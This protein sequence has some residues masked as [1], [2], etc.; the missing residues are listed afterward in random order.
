[1]KK[2]LL[3]SA[4]A[5][6]GLVSTSQAAVT[7]KATEGWLESGFV[8]WTPLE[9]ATGYHVYCRPSGG[10]YTQLD[11]ELVRNYNT[12]GR[13]DVL[14]IKAGEYQFKVVP[15]GADGAEM[16]A[17]ATE[18]PLFTAAAHDR[19]G[20]AHKGSS[21]GIGAY[22]NDGTLKEG[23]R[24]LYVNAN[25]A[26]TV[27]LNMC[28]DAKK[29]T[30]S[31]HVGLQTILAAYEK[32]AEMRPLAIRIV[33]TIKDTN[34]DYIG[35]KEEGLQIKGHAG[36][37]KLNLTIEGVGDDATLH[38]Y[39]MI[40]RNTASVELR[41]FG[42][43]LCLDDAI[44]LDTDNSEIWIHNLD[45]FYGKN[46]GGD[47][48]KGDGSIDIK[49]DSKNVT[50]AYNHL[51]DTG[52]SSLGGMKSESTSSFITYH[53]NWFDH[54][55]SRHPRIRTMSV[56]VFNNYFDGN[57]KYGVGMTYGGSAFVENNYFRNC[58]YPMLTSKQGADADGSGTFSGENG[59]VIKAFGNFIKGGKG[60]RTQLTHPSSYDCYEVA[61]RDEQ[62]PAT[63][64]ALAGGS[65]Y[66]NFDTDASIMYAYTPDAAEA[67]PEKVTGSLGAGR[68]GHGDF[69]WGFNNAEQDEN[70]DIIDDLAAAL[71]SY[72]S[73]LVGY[74]GA[75]KLA[76]GGATEKVNGGEAS[77]GDVDF[78]EEAYIA[79][80]DTK[81]YFW[82]NQANSA[83]VKQMEDDGI[84]LYDKSGNT[85][86]QPTYSYKS[87]GTFASTEHTGAIQLNK[88]TSAGA[89]DGGYVIFRCPKGVTTCGVYL[90]RTGSFY[91]EIEKSSDSLEWKKVATIE[92]APKGILE[93]DLTTS[94][95]DTAHYVFLKI[96][97]TSTGTLYLQ[98]I[99]LYNVSGAPV[100]VPA[101]TIE[102]PLPSDPADDDPIDEPGELAAAGVIYD[103]AAGTGITEM[104][105]VEVSSLKCYVNTVAVDGIKCGNSI[106][107]KNG[108]VSNYYVKI[109]PTS[110]IFVAGDTVVIAGAFNNTD[111]TKLAAIDILD[112][113]AQTLHTTAQFIN[114]R[115]VDGDPVIEKYVL[116]A[117]TRAL[118]L[119]RNGKTATYI[120]T[121]RVIRPESTTAIDELMAD[122]AALD[123]LAPAE[124]AVFDLFGRRAEQLEPGKLYIRGGKKIIVR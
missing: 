20:F 70:Y 17:D 113:Q 44:S 33:G 86:F 30:Y 15:V 79:G 71:V 65:T 24:I 118:Y 81:D 3:I 40:L 64:K 61:S 12:Y 5:L 36:Y 22:N 54:S 41:N 16:T 13:A 58:K 56:H 106:V 124:D 42:V 62:I 90:Y 18:S 93:R 94:V 119:G 110:G 96:Q 115:L 32:G 117:D 103:W 43:M 8:T 11:A 60:V 25:N 55:D 112:D 66:Y 97:N 29:K 27:T 39:G 73:T 98:G 122:D 26:K 45:I 7:L 4:L 99:R 35:S 46:G 109:E 21:E 48:A 104:M 91:L 10:E 105:G 88:A 77:L 114:G 1:M 69:H 108:F 101:P 47:K 19:T 49:A 63:V 23:A 2:S 53:H 68:I 31:D 50:V 82:F 75:D 121:L 28:T 87:D 78:T 102:E 9:G 84:I 76:N 107:A 123:L 38:G 37:Q 89:T 116:K 57:S 34:L 111:N 67:V 52:K 100:R 85:K 14:G 6:A 51:W 120:T 83:T 80:A 74:Y 59:G 95:F 92:K 72:R